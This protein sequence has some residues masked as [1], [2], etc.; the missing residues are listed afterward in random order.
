MKNLVR[1]LVA[2]MGL[3]CLF[4]GLCLTY[5]LGVALTILG[6]LLLAAAV[7]PAW[8]RGA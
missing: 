4:A 2:V 8:R 1:D 7:L 3:G 6:G 5:G